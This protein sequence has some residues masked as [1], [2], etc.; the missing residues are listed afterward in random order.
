MLVE[1]I[2]RPDRAGITIIVDRGQLLEEL[3]DLQQKVTKW[4]YDNICFNMLRDLSDQFECSTS[5]LFIVLPTDID[6]WDDSDPSTHR[7]R[8]NFLND[9]RKK[10]GA[11]K[12]LPQHVHLSKHPGYSLKR[13]EEFFKS[14]AITF[15]RVLQMIK[16]GYSDQNHDIPA[17][18]TLRILW[19]YDTTVIGSRLT[20]DTIKALIDRVISYFRELSPPK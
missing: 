2:E 6:S 7:F 8:I 5:A 1:E 16:H 17:L 12:T 9:Y 18:D 15:L 14:M 20:M 13:P 3:R 19:N 10:L 4:D 11:Q